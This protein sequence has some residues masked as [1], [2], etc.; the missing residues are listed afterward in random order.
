MGSGKVKAMAEKKVAIFTTSFLPT[1]GGL[2]YELKWLL[3]SMDKLLDDNNKNFELHFFGPNKESLKYAR[4]VNIKVSNLDL[5]HFSKY[6]FL[7]N[8]L[9]LHKTLKR[10]KPDIIHCQSAIPDALMVYCN[11][12]FCCMKQRYVITSHGNDIVTLPEINY[13]ARLKPSVDFLTKVVLKKAE[14]HILPSTALIDFAREAGINPDKI[15]IIPN[16]I[17]PIKIKR[18]KEAVTQLKE[19]WNLASRKDLC[20]LSLSS[21]RPIKN[22]DCLVDGFAEAQRH[23]GNL[24]LFLTCEDKTM[25]L[26]SK[27][28]KM[29]LQ[30][31]VQFIGPIEGA[32]KDAYF[33]ICDV[34]CLTSFFENF[35]VSVLEAMD[36]GKI[37]LV[38]KVGGL[39]DFIKDKRNGIF[40]EPGNSNDVADKIQTIYQNKELRRTIQANAKQSVKSYYIDNIAEQYLKLYQTA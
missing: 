6:N 8:V 16:G 2:Q 37:V 18:N 35:P 40:V 20:L 26:R 30:D 3:D 22:L 19:K 31:K 1:I 29:K 12:L 13:G 11:N 15:R 34:F 7:E 27:V 14:K 25:R 23:I 4:F 39:I 38:S 28:R 5:K 9:K 24:K 17:E 36:Y 33:Q 32:R 10:I 21:T